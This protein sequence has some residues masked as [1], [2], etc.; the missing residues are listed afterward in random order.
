MVTV[1][2]IIVGELETNCYIVWEEGKSDA[3]V[4]DP[5]A[6]AERIKQLLNNLKLSPEAV[7][8]THGHADHMS[9]CDQL[10]L[11]VY[12]NEED[13]DFLKHPELNLSAFVS[14]PVTVN[15]KIIVFKDQDELRFRKS[16]LIFKV[17]HTPGH[18][19]G[20][21]CFLTGDYLFSGDTLFKAGIGRTDFPGASEDVFITSIKEKLL[22]LPDGI[23]VYP[24]HGDESTIAGEK[25]YNPFLI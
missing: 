15:Q 21:C 14:R 18:T 7:L 16:G 4:I 12:L 20:G 1:E 5:G 10:G 25:K 11:D 19:P 2:K 6:D 23:K 9:S 22:I 13:L 24:G 8:L 3:V 17:I